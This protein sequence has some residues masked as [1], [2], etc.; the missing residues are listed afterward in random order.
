MNAITKTEQARPSLIAMMAAKHNMEPEA[1]A[2]TVRATVMPAQHTNEQFAAL[3]LVAQEYDLNPIVKEIYAFPAKGGGIVPIVSIDGWINLVNS[4]PQS[5]GFEFEFE[6][7]EEK[8]LVSCT[9]R[10][11]RKDRSRQV[12]VTEYLAECKR[13]TDPWKME[14]RML[15]HKAMIQAARLAFGF[16]GVYDD[17]EGAKIAEMRDVT[18]KQPPAPPPPPAPPKSEQAADAEIIEDNDRETV[19]P[20]TGEIINRDGL[21]PSEY[22]QELEL[23]MAGAKTAEDVEE[24]WTE[25]DP[26]ARFDGDDINQ[27]IATAIKNRRLKRW[28][29]TMGKHELPPLRMIVERGRL[30]PASPYDQ[31]RL[32]GYQNGARLQVTLWQGRNGKLSRKYWAIL[33]KVVADLPCPWQTAEEASDALKLACGITDAGKT[34]NDQWFIRPGSISFSTMPEDK[35]QDFFERAMA[36]LARVTGVDPTTLGQAAADVGDEE[37]NSD[38]APP[39]SSSDEAGNSSQAPAD[40]DGDGDSSSP[41]LPSNLS[42]DEREQ[43]IECARKIMGITKDDISPEEQFDNVTSTKEAWIDAM[44]EAR[45]KIKTIAVTA[46]AVIAGKRTRAQ[47]VS[48]LEE[49]MDAEGQIGG[50][51]G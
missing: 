50:G 51:N 40:Q 10:M 16:S 12:A 15:R 27:G 44:P 43:L 20:D 18:P 30:V 33:H 29:P 38:D 23:A 11:F 2:K 6:H 7:D 42:E 46:Q 47:A 41:P 14:H 8:K 48:F 19:D 17:D 37:D 28:R 21:E 39:P 1:F 9:C 3:M 22:F 36:V 4:H 5:D 32:D 35:F 13:N 24:A 31:E 34:V 45:D 49:M 26:L 25:F